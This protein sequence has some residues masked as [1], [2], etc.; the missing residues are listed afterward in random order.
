MTLHARQASDA[1]TVRCEPMQH[2]TAGCTVVH[3]AIDFLLIFFLWWGTRWRLL[4]RGDGLLLRRCL[5][6][7]DL[8]DGM[9]LEVDFLVLGLEHSDGVG[10]Q[11]VWPSLSGGVKGLHDL[12]LNPDNTLAQCDVN[13]SLVDVVTCRL[14][15]VDHEAIDELHGLRTLRTQLARDDHLAT[16]GTVLNDE[17]HHT[18]AR[19]ANEWVENELRCCQSEVRTQEDG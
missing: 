12:D 16:L 15:G 18:V 9:R 7:L 19:T 11:F 2:T 6:L 5:L 14:T 17:P 8:A 10:Q 3:V 13:A 4:G 1:A